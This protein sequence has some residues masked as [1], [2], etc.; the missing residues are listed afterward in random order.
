[1]ML[2][3]SSKAGNQYDAKIRLVKGIMHED[4]S[5]AKLKE[6]ADELGI[7]GLVYELVTWDKEYERAILAV[8]SDWIKATVVNDFAALVSLAEYVKYKKLPKLKIIPLEAI[9]KFSLDLPGKKGILGV[10]SDYVACDPK[11]SALKTFLFGNVILADSRD[12]AYRLSKSGY[13][14]VTLAGEF[15]ESNAAAV[16]IDINSK[17]SNLTKIISMSTSV[18]GLLASISLLK[19]YVQKKKTRPKGARGEPAK[20]SGAPAGLQY[21]ACCQQPEL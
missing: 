5:T 21:G 6:N 15:F 1:M 12:S 2:E 20:L 19:K 8:S 4:Y 10:L 13:K 16:V 17:I 7:L 18:D 3:K 14:S 11:Y 9:P